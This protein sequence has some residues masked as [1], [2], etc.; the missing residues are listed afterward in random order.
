MASPP[1]ITSDESFS[2]RPTSSSSR[3]HGSQAGS[4]VSMSFHNSRYSPPCA[5]DLTPKQSAL[6]TSA[7]HIM[8]TYLPPAF[9]GLMAGSAT[10]AA[11]L[12]G[13]GPS[14][15]PSGECYWSFICRTISKKSPRH[16]FRPRRYYCF[17]VGLYFKTPPR[18]SRAIVCCRCAQLWIDTLDRTHFF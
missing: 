5:L 3:H 14:F 11:G 12:P 4:P 18:T 13:H 9:A 17:G 16:P 8:S 7:N 2:P 1:L 6:T 10:S 15:G